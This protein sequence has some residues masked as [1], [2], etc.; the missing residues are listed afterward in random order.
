[1]GAKQLV[2]TIEEVETHEP[3][4]TREAEAEPW[5]TVHHRVGELGE[6]LKATY[7]KVADGGGPSE[8]EIRQ[9]LTTLAGVW[10]QVSSSLGPVLEDPEVRRGLK[11]T[12]ASLADALGDTIGGVS[13][14]WQDDSEEE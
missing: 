4:P 5:N 6:R 11:L 3:D 1:M 12:A 13:R 7:L 14:E 10:E 9:A 8:E 2:G